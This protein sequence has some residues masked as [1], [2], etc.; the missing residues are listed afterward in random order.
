LSKHVK[1][2]DSAHFDFNEKGIPV[3]SSNYYG[4]V[5]GSYVSFDFVSLPKWAA[6]VLSFHDE[7]VRTAFAS[8]PTRLTY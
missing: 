5:L 1:L 3:I 4:V 6:F 8:P 7:K 2:G